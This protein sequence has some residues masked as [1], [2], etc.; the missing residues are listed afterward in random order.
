MLLLLHFRVAN[1]ASHLRRSSTVSSRWESRLRA[2]TARIRQIQAQSGEADPSLSL[3]SP[4]RQLNSGEAE[5]ILDT[6]SPRGVDP[7]AFEP[8]E[9][10]GVPDAKDG[11]KKGSR[12]RHTITEGMVKAESPSLFSRLFL[13]KR[14]KRSPL[15]HY[16]SSVRSLKTQI[17]I[18]DL[19]GMEASSSSSSSSSH[20]ADSGLSSSVSC[21]DCVPSPRIKQR[22]SYLREEKKLDD[23]EKGKGRRASK[24]VSIQASAFLFRVRRLT[25]VIAIWLQG[26]TEKREQHRL[27][28][29]Q[30]EQYR[31]VEVG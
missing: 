9:V 25:H 31:E 7:G 28:A 12:G 18:S 13:R 23:K 24:C 26:E 21:A 2:H 17:S 22:Q 3:P 29:E 19:N 8:P 5:A 11:G 14:S 27:Q 30:P 20:P 15:P 1:P 10:N 4:P 16:S 6:G